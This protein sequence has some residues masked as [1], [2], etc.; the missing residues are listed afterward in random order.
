MELN[1]NSIPFLISNRTQVMRP[2]T[3]LHLN[4]QAAYLIQKKRSFPD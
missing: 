2:S 3:V 4:A 1:S